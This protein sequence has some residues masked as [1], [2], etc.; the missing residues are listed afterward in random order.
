MHLSPYLGL[1]GRLGS[2]FGVHG[3]LA[4][5]LLLDGPEPPPVVALGSA[6]GRQARE[7]FLGL[8]H[9]LNKGGGWSRNEKKKKTF[10]IK[11]KRG[12]SEE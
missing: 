8:A 2:L 3:Q 12:R 5:V 11:R 6:R 9:D 10:A 7:G 4:S 1:D